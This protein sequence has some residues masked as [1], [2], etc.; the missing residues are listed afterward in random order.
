MELDFEILEKYPSIDVAPIEALLNEEMN[1]NNDKIVVLDDDPTGVQTVHDISVYTD[2]SY[3]SIQSGFREK[4]KIFYILTNS[5]GFSIEQTTK[6]HHEIGKRIAEV[7]REEKKGYFIV[8]RGDST[9]RGHYP[10]ETKVLKDEFENNSDQKIDG[11][12]LC[13]FFKEGG[14]YTVGN[15]HYVKDNQKLIPAA[16]TEFA[17]DKTFGYKSSNLCAYIEEKTQGAY[18]QENVVTI[19][20]EELRELK[21]DEITR[22][23]LTIQNFD[24]VVVNAIDGS[25]LKVFCVALYRAI[26]KGKRFLFRTAAG[27]VKELAG[28]HDRPLLTKSEMIT[29]DIYTGGIIVVG[30]HTV[31]TTS[32]LEA[33]KEI[34]GI[35]FIELNSDL[36][37]EEGLL[38]EEV[39]SVVQQE[40]ALLRDGK[41]VVVYTK[42]TLLTLEEDSKEDALL[43]S[44]K[45]SD[46]VQ[47][48]VGRLTVTPSFVVAK[49]GITS[50]D[51]GTKALQVKKAR[52]LGQIKP[53]IPV[54]Q[55]G[56]ESKFPQTPY[57]IFPGN[58]GE[59]STLKEVVEILI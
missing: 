15:I 21:I 37:L 34:K 1:K 48:L 14:R 44:V 17:K 26:A 36:V 33:L 3:N 47:S 59:D 19:S 43:R 38:E 12:I 13:P 29:K 28:I 39:K 25:D 30:S 56:K 4:N 41:T 42:R 16:E 52:V 54:W 5:R 50:S 18:L 55:T 2:W 57:I 6:A 20:L 40:E 46:A 27:F 10:L 7:A 8:S 9:L 31:K 32:Q 35:E 11:E 22:K 45:I 53:G 23:L 58:V 49:G 24:K 51:V